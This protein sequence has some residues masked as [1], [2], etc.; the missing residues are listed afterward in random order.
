MFYVQT[1]NPKINRAADD[2]ERFF[3]SLIKG[4]VALPDFFTHTKDTPKDVV[5]RIRWKIDPNTLGGVRKTP[6]REYTSKW[7]WSKVLGYTS[8]GSIFVNTRFSSRAEIAEIAGNLAHEYCHVLGYGHKG[9]KV[10]PYNLQS[11]PY[12]IGYACREFVRNGF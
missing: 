3:D 8:R 10:T 12:V 6:V 5:E 9:N 2:A 7:P 4:E 1:D 11:V